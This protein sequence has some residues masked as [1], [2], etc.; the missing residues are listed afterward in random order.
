MGFTYVAGIPDGNANVTMNINVT[1]DGLIIFGG[2]ALNTMI[3]P[4]NRFLNIV[5]G[6]IDGGSTGSIVMDGVLLM[7]NTGNNTFSDLRVIGSKFGSTLRINNTDGF[8]EIRMSDHINNRILGVNG[9]ETIIF[10]S[11]LTVSGSGQIGANLTTLINEGTIVAD[12][13]TRL[14]VDPDAGGMINSGL[15]VARDGGELRLHLANYDNALGEIRAEDGSTVRFTSAANIFGGQIVAQSGGLLTISLC[16]VSG[17]SFQIDVGG[18]G[19]ILNDC[20]ILNLNNHGV[21]NHNANAIMNT[22][23]QMTNTGTYFLNSAGEGTLTDIRFTGN[24]VLDGGGTL[25]MS[26][27]ISNRIYGIT[28]TQIFTNVDNTI[29]GSGN[30]GL[31]LMSIINQGTII[32]DQSNV[33]RIDPNSDGFTNSGTLRA[34]NGATLRIDPDPFTTSGFVFAEAGSIIRRIVAG[35]IQT[36]GS[37]I[38]DGALTLNAGQTVTLNGGV[39][40][41]SG[42]INAH[43]NNVAGTASPGSSA[44]TLT[45]NGNYTQGNNASFAVEIGGTRPGQ[46]DVLA[47]NGNASLGGTLDVTFIDGFDPLVGQMFTVLTANNVSGVFD[48]VNSCAGLNVAYNA[49]SVVLR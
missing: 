22:F 11:G 31:N 7:Q 46:Y 36:A 34:E 33:L 26:N 35:Y 2:K 32:A 4:S 39:L 41:G 45:V 44:G 30:I 24:T 49:T 1:L 25:I 5:G 48:N 19:Q 20:T 42:Q 37:T 28:G 43:V 12:Q 14:S 10:G 47:I 3:I 13:K 23:S 27:Q 40:G 8:G 9:G 38:I 29:R 21:I 6:P 18:A 15:M 16:S 17:D